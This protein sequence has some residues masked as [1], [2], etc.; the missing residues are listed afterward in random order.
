MS[1]GPEHQIEHA[2]HAA[3]ASHNLFDT[4]VTISIAAI[5]AVLACVA[6]L[7]H[8]AHNR[9]LQLQNDA[10]RE[11]TEA[12]NKWAYYQT[13]NLM[14]FEAKLLL[15]QMKVFAAR[16]GSQAEAEAVRAHYQAIVD[17]YDKKLPKIEEEASQIAAS[18]EKHAVESEHA[19]T[20][21]N[22]FDFGELGL[23]LAVVLCSLA[24]LTKRRG[25]WY[26][27]LLSALAGCL[28][29]L[30]GLYDPFFGGH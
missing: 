16:E 23:Q 24:I 27:G 7:G 2:E 10:G 12:A 4:R 21:A 3:H 1:H 22:R 6:M 30:T 18:G 5:A 29:A 26:A 13:K 14:N 19:H 17:K 9:T 15:D 20:W 25:F 11:S 8:R 28:V